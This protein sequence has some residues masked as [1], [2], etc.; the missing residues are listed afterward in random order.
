M[1]PEATARIAEARS[2]IEIKGLTFTQTAKALGISRSA[3]AGLTDRHGIKSPNPPG[4]SPRPNH[5]KPR[6]KAARARLEALQ[7][8]PEL[9]EAEEPLAAAWLALPGST[10]VAVEHHLPDTCKWPV[11][12]PARFCA[13]PV[14][15]DPKGVRTYHYC[16]AHH[17][18]GTRPWPERKP[19]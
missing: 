2:L 12:S 6:A 17:A 10:P 15:L 3:I 13:L 19:K 18:I 1:T 7:R 11:L 8:P 14:H 5:A 16:P 4:R 9:P